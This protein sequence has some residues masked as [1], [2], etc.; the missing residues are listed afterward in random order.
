MREA[1]CSG[2]SFRAVASQIPSAWDPGQAEGRLGAEGLEGVHDDVGPAPPRCDRGAHW[3]SSASAAAA[4]RASSAR[5]SGATPS[6]SQTKA[7]T[8]S[9]IRCGEVQRVAEQRSRSRSRRRARSA[10]P[11]PR[12]GPPPVRTRPTRRRAAPP[13]RSSSASAS[14][15]PRRP[16]AGAAPAAP[17]PTARSRARTRRAA[18][19]AMGTAT[20][21]TWASRSRS[22]PAASESS[23]SRSKSRSLAHLSAAISTSSL[24]VE[25]VVDRAGRHAGLARDVR[26]AGRSAKPRCW[27][28]RL[29]AASI[30]SGRFGARGGRNARAPADVV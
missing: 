25:V 3:P 15:A 9:R 12:R 24:I 10:S 18:G 28:A 5:A 13:R 29:A 11:P 26:D 2:R 14:R 20:S 23:S 27:M 22:L 17:A 16:G 21:S 1:E 8:R 6:C 4:V 30:C 19:R 7:S